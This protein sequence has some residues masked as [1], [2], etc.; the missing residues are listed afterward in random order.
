MRRGVRSRAGRHGLLF[1][2]VAV[3]LVTVTAGS[4]A[5]VHYASLGTA[6]AGMGP[7]GGTSPA[8]PGAHRAD[9]AALRNS[10]RPAT[11]RYGISSASPRARPAATPRLALHASQLT[12]PAFF[13]KR[14]PSPQVPSG[15][16][17]PPLAAGR[18][19]PPGMKS[20]NLPHHLP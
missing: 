8:G 20:A 17:V 4:L 2:V 11:P 14:P 6:P 15:T 3:L 12:A 19:D 13:P 9:T 5:I 7:A 1:G 18:P 16:E 10:T